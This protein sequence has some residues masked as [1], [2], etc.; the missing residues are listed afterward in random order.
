MGHPPEA[1]DIISEMGLIFLLFMIGLEI[2]L[3]KISAAGRSITDSL[4]Q[5]VGG[6][7]LGWPQPGAIGFPPQ[8][9]RRLGCVVPGSRLRSTAPSSSSR[10]SD[11]GNSIPWPGESPGRARPRD[12]AVILFLAIQPSLDHL[13]MGSIAWS[14]FKVAVLR[15]GPCRQPLRAPRFFPTRGAIA[16]TGPGRRARL[17]F[18]VG[19]VCRFPGSVAGDGALVAGVALSTFPYALTSRPR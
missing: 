11:K 12:L 17:V 19:Q 2:D 6:A 3:K 9:R 5:I 15:L 18:S 8:S 4:V 7:A 14:V 13:Q 16:G 10:F 1:I